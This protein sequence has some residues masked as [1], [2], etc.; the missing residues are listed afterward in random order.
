RDL[1]DSKDL[2]LV[3]DAAQAHGA[4]YKDRHVGGFGDAGAFSLYPTK[5]MTSGEGGMVTTDD[6][7]L[8]EVARSFRNHGRGLSTLGTYDH[9]RFGYNYRLT[10]LGSAIGRVQLGRL[11]GWVEA[12]RANAEALDEAFAD[13]PGIVTP[14]EAEHCVHAYHQYSIRAGDRD[15]LQAA[16]KERGVGSGIYYPKPAFEYPHL[17]RFAKACPEA[18]EACRDVLSLPVH[19]GLSPEEVVTIS[20]AVRDAVLAVA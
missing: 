20:Q 5:N 1:C 7:Q 6:D 17:A 10:D 13:V 16:L 14:V 18:Q 3:E 8:A 9:V 2:V 11:D 4:R 19:P 15:R 12:R